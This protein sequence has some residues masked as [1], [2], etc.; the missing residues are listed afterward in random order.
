MSNA[1]CFSPVAA[2][3][4]LLSDIDELPCVHLGDFTLTLELNE[5]SDRTKEVARE[6]LRETAEVVGPAVDRLRE[7]L[8]GETL[9]LVY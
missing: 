4:A 8:A 3:T 9:P 7:L 1:V 6:E 2:K 5:M